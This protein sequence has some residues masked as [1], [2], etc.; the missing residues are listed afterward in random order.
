MFFKKLK[1]LACILGIATALTGNVQAA[2]KYIYIDDMSKVQFQLLSNNEV[3]FRNLHAFDA[4]VTGC[5]YAFR[6]DL[7]S[8]YGKNAWSTILMKMAS[9]EKLYLHVSESN[10]PTS[11]NPAVIDHLGIW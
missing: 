10:P 7:N 11:G 9:K 8:E 1:Y 6:L 5:C 4:S 2:A 3:Y